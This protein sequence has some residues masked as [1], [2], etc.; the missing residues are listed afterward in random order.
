[1]SGAEDG[2]REVLAR[3][4]SAN[5]AAGVTGSTEP[6]APS[7]PSVPSVPRDY[8]TTGA[9]AA[10]SVEV[11]DLLEDRLVDYRAAVTRCYDAGVADAVRAALDAAGARR[12]VVPPGLPPEWVPA[13]GLDTVVIDDGSLSPAQLD[14]MDAVVTASTAAAAVTGTIVLDGSPDQGRR[15]ISLVPDVHVCVVGAQQVVHSV[16]ELLAR[17]EPSRPTTFIS[18]PSATSDIELERVEGVHGPRTLH[19]V[20]VIE[21]DDAA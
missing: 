20:L 5:R 4:R 18:G 8:A 14:E 7:G 19:V 15:A 3:I 6:T 21:P 9:L 13:T 1:M 16:P 17:L 12:V 11:I 10:G 2:R